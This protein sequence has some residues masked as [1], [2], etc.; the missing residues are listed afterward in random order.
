MSRN[1]AGQNVH[2][3]S[4]ELSSPA[5]YYPHVFTITCI[6]MK[7]NIPV[8]RFLSNPGE[9]KIPNRPP[10]KHSEDVKASFGY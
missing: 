10:T 6:I 5:L 4:Q 9:K 1:A 2:T 8:S 7:K 3:G